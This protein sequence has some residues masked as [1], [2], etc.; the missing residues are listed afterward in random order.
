M[1]FEDRRQALVDA[2][3]RVIARDGLAAATTRAIVGEA[4]MP[5]GALFYIFSSRDA[6]ITEVITHITEQERL[7]AVLSADMV[8]DDASLHE[9]LSEAMLG[10]LR[11]LEEDPAREL[12]LL[13]VATHA[14]RHDRA[15]VNKQWQTYRSAVADALSY[16]ADRMSITWELPLT[17][18]AH[19]VTSAIDGLTLSWLTDRDTEAARRNIDVLATA[20]V[21]LAAPTA[22]S[23]AAPEAQSEPDTHA[24]PEAPEAPTAPETDAR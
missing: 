1:T 12:A 8:A 21:T 11:M 23:A 19:L 2:A 16:L 5:Q 3:V 24:A 18:V 7:T 9:V 13:E 4:G 6:L 17:Q 10:Y 20:I 22:G 14:I 15:A